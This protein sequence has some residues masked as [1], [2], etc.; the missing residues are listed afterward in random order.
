[1]TRLTQKL[2]IIL[3]TACLALQCLSTPFTSLTPLSNSPAI[4]DG[5][6]DDL[7]ITMT[8]PGEMLICCEMQHEKESE[9]ENVSEWK[10]DAVRE[11]SSYA[12]PF[13]LS[14]AFR[15]HSENRNYASPSYPFHRPPNRMS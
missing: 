3:L 9:S 12:L 5:F 11:S 4:T 15:P 10:L 7:R 6:T 8:L 13:L 2:L 1:M 14:A